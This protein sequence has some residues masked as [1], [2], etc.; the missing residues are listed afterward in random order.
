V[1]LQSYARGLYLRVANTIGI[2]CSTANLTTRALNHYCCVS[3]PRINFTP[4]NDSREILT[5]ALMFRSDLVIRGG[6]ESANRGPTDPNPLGNLAL[7]Q[8]LPEEGL[9]LLH[10]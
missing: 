9:Y 3:A 6:K 1:I 8:A 4:E 5:Q 2:V 10:V 7:G